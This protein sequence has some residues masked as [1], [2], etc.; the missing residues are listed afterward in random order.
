M[1]EHVEQL[2]KLNWYFIL[3][4]CLCLQ[5]RLGYRTIRGKKGQKQMKENRKL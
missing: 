4:I 3:E 1:A 2:L 5:Y